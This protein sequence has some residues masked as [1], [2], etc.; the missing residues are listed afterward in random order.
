M[1][2]TQK[3][4]S[5]LFVSNKPLSTEQLAKF[6]N[7]SAQETEVALASL[8]ESKKQDGIIL[9]NVNG[10][11]QLATHPENVELVKTFLNAD[12]R[13]KLTDATVEVLGIIAYRQPISK[14]E[15]ES[16]R[17]V[18][19]QYSVRQLLM[20]GLIEKV[21]NP[22][23]NRSNLYQVTTEFL[24]HLGLQSVNDLPEFEKLT[25][26]IKLPE[27]PQTQPEAAATS[28]VLTPETG[29][30]QTYQDP[31]GTTP[32]PISP[33]DPDVTA[34]FT[35]DTEEELTDDDDEDGDEED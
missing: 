9:L 24:Q 27:T 30:A 35:E 17:G 16:I 22:N 23:D 1:E 11:W 21:A 5:V 20:R 8:A 12:L 10:Y 26:S 33:N 25:S 19:S 18:N 4:E 14:A 32:A 3:L 6:V 34:N 31:V 29:Q 15:I 28:N 7:A 2:L 13:E